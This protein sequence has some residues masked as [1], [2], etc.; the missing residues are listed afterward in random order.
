MQETGDG[1]C[2]GSTDFAQKGGGAKEID[3][4]D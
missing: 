1:V 4:P 3:Y 2:T